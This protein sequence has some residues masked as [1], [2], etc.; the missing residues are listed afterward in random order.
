MKLNDLENRTYEG[1]QCIYF[2][3]VMKIEKDSKEIPYFF[4][5]YKDKENDKLWNMQI[6]EQGDKYRGSNVYQFA[7]ET[8]S[9]N[10]ALDMIACIGLSFYQQYLQESVSIDSEIIGKIFDETETMKG[11]TQ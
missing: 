8:K 9:K 3:Y 6:I 4:D 2:R 1:G 7:F 11:R 10:V 5:F